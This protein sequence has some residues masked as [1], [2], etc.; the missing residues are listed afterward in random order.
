MS[1][2]VLRRP[3]IAPLALL[4]VGFLAVSLP[5]YLGLDPSQSRVPI[6]FS[7]HYPVLV[8]HIGFGSIALLA[9]CLQ[10]WPWLRQHHPKVHR[11]SGRAY[12]FL[13]VLPA[14]LASLS[15][16]PFGSFGATQQAGNSLL[17]LLWL[18]TTLAGYRMARQRRYAAHC[19]WMIRSFA[20]GYS[21]VLN[22]LWQL[23]CFLVFTPELFAGEPVDPA[24]M[25]QAVGA[26]VWL[27]WVVNLLVAEWWLQRT[28]Q[29]T[30][31]PPQSGRREKA[32]SHG[33]VPSVG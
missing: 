31:R 11:Y 6:R 2:A 30:P 8:T 12:V 20:L 24:A 33:E 14:G 32:R 7:W 17:A 15:F 19:E 21:I 13:G 25:G 26:S 9:G 10:L 16:A 5:P 1:L 3:W 27:S 28:R 23:I 18:A 22:R 4:T 29:H